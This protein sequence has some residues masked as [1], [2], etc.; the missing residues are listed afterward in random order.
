MSGQIDDDV[1]NIPGGV[2]QMHPYADGDESSA[3]PT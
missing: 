1:R 3:S 2:D